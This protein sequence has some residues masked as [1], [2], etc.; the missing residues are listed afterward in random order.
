MD[1][2]DEK[3]KKMS[4]RQYV[5]DLGMNYTRMSFLNEK[6]EEGF[7]TEN[8]ELLHLM[9]DAD[10][11]VEIEY[12]GQRLFISEIVKKVSDTGIKKMIIRVND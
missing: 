9:N 6:I 10:A 7:Q 12:D 4:P 8:N 5:E 2:N 3:F 1:A 11:H